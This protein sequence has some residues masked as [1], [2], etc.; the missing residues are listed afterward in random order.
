MT[1]RP[2]K[3][4]WRKLAEREIKASPDTLIWNTPEGIDVKPLYTADDLEGIDH[5]GSLPGIEPFLRG[6]RATMYT[7]RPWTIRQYAGFSTAEA[8]NNFY[9]KALAAG[10]QGVSVAFDL[11]THR[12]YDSD[13]P[14]VEGDVGKAGVAIDSVEDMKILF[15]GIPLEQIS[16]SM[17]MNGAVIPILANFIVAGE[18]QGVSRDKL[19]GTIQNDILKEFMVRNTYI[20]PPEPSMRIVADIIEYTAK[21]M[22][23]FNSISI[24]GYH[25]QEAGSTLVQELAF[26]LADGREYVRAALKKGLNVDDFAGRLSFFFAIGMNFFMEAAKLRAA[27][28]LW[29]RIMTEFE[30]KKASSLMLRTH[31]QTSGVS[32]QEQDPYNNI[33]RTAFEA[34]SAALGG[35]QSL[36]TNSFDEAIALPTEFSARIARNTQLILQHETGVTKVVDPLAGSY[37]VEALTNDLAEKAWALIE[38]VEAMG[39]MT[40]AVA[41]GLPKRLIEEAAT[42]KQA[43]IDRGDEVIVGVNKYRLEQEDEIDILEIDNS[44]V[45]QAQVERIERTRRQ[46][47]PKRVEAAI[48]ALEQVART[49]EGNI[50]AAAVDASRARATVGEISDAMRRAFGD[51]AAVPEVVENVYGKA[52]DD[53]P[54]F[55]TL[56]SRLEQ[57]A[58][59]LGEKPRIMVAKLGQDGHDRGAKVIASAFGDIGFEVIAGPLFQTPDEAADTAI[60]SRVHVVGMSSLAAGHKTLAPQLVG[61]LKA[62][63][64]DNII[65]VVGGVIPRQDYQYLLDHGV[66]AVFG[67]GTNVLDAARA[68]LDLMEGKRRNQ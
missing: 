50:L 66:A 13:H 30:P 36:H 25:M 16:V 33:V 18:E 49:G 32:L 55:R 39:G 53:E 29:S 4:D 51:H 14:R 15:D 48:V 3:A 9:R 7:G 26:T 47:D 17:T 42:R 65:V 38:E 31:C 58:G 35:T 24:S 1:D 21:E 37:Y 6:P 64:A 8:S 11:A 57:F 34:M 46:R 5:I 54:E 44:A 41:T 2:T 56:V 10:Q 43:A 22:P 19:S 52:Y 63:G 68:V 23:K 61:A 12:G 59:S 28:L 60:A 62:K 45:R 40:K 67:P 20:Y 27:R